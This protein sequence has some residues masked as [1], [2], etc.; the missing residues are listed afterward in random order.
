MSDF[1]AL[2]IA[3]KSNEFGRLEISAMFAQVS[4]S[5][6]TFLLHFMN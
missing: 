4:K 3:L 1:W 6:T 2:A 5:A